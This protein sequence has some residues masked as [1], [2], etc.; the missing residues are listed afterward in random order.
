MY[1]FEQLKLKLIFLLYF[2]KSQYNIKLLLGVEIG[3]ALKG[4]S[5][6]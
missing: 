3:E 6:A 4:L 5:L 2:H 1:N